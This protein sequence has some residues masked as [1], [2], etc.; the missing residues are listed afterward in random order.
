MALA[1]RFARPISFTASFHAAH[2]T[3]NNDGSD[4]ECAVASD[5]SMPPLAHDS[6][7]ESPSGSSDH[8]RGE[9]STEREASAEDEE[10]QDVFH[11]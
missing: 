4:E 1:R 3:I 11:V 6:D 7:T 2:P 10:P 8:Y 5:D 9:Q